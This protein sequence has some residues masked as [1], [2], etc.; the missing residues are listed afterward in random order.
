MYKTKE[1]LNQSSQTTKKILKKIMQ[2][3]IH[4]NRRGGGWAWPRGRQGVACKVLVDH[5]RG[6]F[7]GNSG[8]WT[9]GR[10]R[11]W[12]R[13]Q[14]LQDNIN[15]FLLPLFFLSIRNPTSMVWLDTQ[16]KNNCSD[17]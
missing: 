17:S 2:D 15:S 8:A 13:L 5:A 12:T 10:R 1:I 7:A 3:K 4:D 14:R 9:W 16:K 6:A 11:N